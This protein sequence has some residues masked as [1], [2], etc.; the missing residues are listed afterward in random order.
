L[1]ISPP[2]KATDIKVWIK[3]EDRQTTKVIVNRSSDIDDLRNLV[4]N[5]NSDRDLY[6][7]YYRNQQLKSG[8]DVPSDTKDDQPV[9]FT[10]KARPTPI[11]PLME[12]PVTTRVRMHSND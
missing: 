9:I 5:G 6:Q 11:Q 7:A 8:E 10:K 12:D 1:G 2:R 4:F 3:L